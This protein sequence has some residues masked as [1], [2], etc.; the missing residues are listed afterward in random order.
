MA[1]HIVFFKDVKWIAFL[2][3][4]AVAVVLFCYGNVVLPWKKQEVQ[5]VEQQLRYKYMREEN[6]ISAHSSELFLNEVEEQLRR[7]KW[8][9]CISK[10]ER[11]PHMLTIQ[12]FMGEHYMIM[13]NSHEIK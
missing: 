13:S 2:L 8:K 7:Y 4:A 1:E 5:Q 12:F 6:G 3:I 9:Y 10:L 11:T